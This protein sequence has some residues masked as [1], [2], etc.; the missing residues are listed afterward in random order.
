VI[1]TSK[2]QEDENKN[3]WVDKYQ[4][5]WCCTRHKENSE[6]PGIDS[7]CWKYFNNGHFCNSSRPVVRRIL[8]EA[9]LDVGPTKEGVLC[10]YDR[11]KSGDNDERGFAVGKSKYCNP[12]CRKRKARDKYN[13]ANRNSNV[14]KK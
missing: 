12:N 1:N 7:V 3:Y 6:R 11:C 5:Y 13:L 8:Y 2:I 10:D 9:E 14:K 4:D